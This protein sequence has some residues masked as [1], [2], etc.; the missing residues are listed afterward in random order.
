M[1]HKLLCGR[2]QNLPDPVL[3]T[4]AIEDVRSQRTAFGH[5]RM[6]EVINRIV[7]HANAGHDRLG[8]DIADSR[9]RDYLR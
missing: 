3:R 1:R 5:Q 6:V 9:E 8:S 7:R 4:E 2:F